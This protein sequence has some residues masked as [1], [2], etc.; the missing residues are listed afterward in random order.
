MNTPEPPASPP[1]HNH[2][3][4]RTCVG[5]HC[6]SGRKKPRLVTLPACRKTSLWSWKSCIRHR[7]TSAILP[8]AT[9]RATWVRTTTNG[10]QVCAF[11]DYPTYRKHCGRSRRRSSRSIR[12][13]RA[14]FC[15][16]NA[17]WC[18]R[19]CFSRGCMRSSTSSLARPRPHTESCGVP[20]GIPGRTS[21]A[22]PPF[23]SNNGPP[24]PRWES[25]KQRS[26]H[27]TQLGVPQATGRD[28]PIEII[29]RTASTQVDVC[30]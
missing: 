15:C 8:R 17:N 3:D 27:A 1:A 9:A 28:E 26:T 2:I 23:S 22:E 12:R 7:C 5:T 20:P 14:N 11:K 21:P 19:L 18:A 25:H 29:Q 10:K 16:I 4:M 6:A 24:K 30:G 13:L